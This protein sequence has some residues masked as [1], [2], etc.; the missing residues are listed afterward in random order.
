MQKRLQPVGR[1]EQQRAVTPNST[2]S[3]LG[4]AAISLQ[5]QNAILEQNLLQAVPHNHQNGDHL[6]L[7]LTSASVT[8]TIS[9]SISHRPA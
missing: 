1:A 4:Q 5:D 8:G 2:V 6:T 3:G 9:R 7:Y